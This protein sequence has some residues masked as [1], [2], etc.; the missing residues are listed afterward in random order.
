MLLKSYQIEAE[1]TS[2]L[3]NHVII[4]GQL[5]WNIHLGHFYCLAMVEI[6]WVQ[7]P[8]FSP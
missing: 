3:N 4:I 1:R 5:V 7:D 6:R 2:T 8:R